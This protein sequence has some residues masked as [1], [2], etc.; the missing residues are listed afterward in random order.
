M[1]ALL[2]AG[3]W[4]ETVKFIEKGHIE[5]IVIHEACVATPGIACGIDDRQ[6]PCRR[7]SRCGPSSLAFSS[8]RTEEAQEG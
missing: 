3:G 7:D 1:I 2:T 5:D 6:C 4:Q 8:S